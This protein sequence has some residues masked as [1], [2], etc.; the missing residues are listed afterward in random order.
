MAEHQGELRLTNRAEGGL[1]ASLVL[2]A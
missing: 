2:P 1:E